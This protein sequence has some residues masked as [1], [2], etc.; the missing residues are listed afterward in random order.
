VFARSAALLDW[1]QSASCEFKEVSLM[2]EDRNVR[3]EDLENWKPASG[4]EYGCDIDCA[5][6]EEENDCCC[7]SV[8]RKSAERS[9]Q[10]MLS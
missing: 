6:D 9:R 7:R 1:A 10:C 8:A 3:T 4:S 2:A 5:R